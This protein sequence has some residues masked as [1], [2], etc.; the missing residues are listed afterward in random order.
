MKNE[1]GFTLIELLASLLIVSVIIILLISIL[2]N[3]INATNR[4]TTNQRLQQEANYI[5]QVIRKEYLVSIFLK[6][7]PIELKVDGN[8]LLMDNQEISSGYKYTLIETSNQKL[9]IPR[10]DVVS[11]KLKISKDNQSYTLNTKFSKID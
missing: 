5:E 8:S 10:N 7:N 3:G 2:L 11:L 4:N 9:L 1:K 6:Q